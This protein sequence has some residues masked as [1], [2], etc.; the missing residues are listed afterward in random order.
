MLLIGLVVDTFSRF[1][2]RLVRICR[3]FS[4]HAAAFIAVFACRVLPFRPEQW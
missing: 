4:L 1:P 2:P 3:E